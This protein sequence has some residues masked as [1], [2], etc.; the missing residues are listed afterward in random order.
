MTARQSAHGE[1]REKIYPRLT[2]PPS[3]YIALLI[4][5]PCHYGHKVRTESHGAVRTAPCGTRA[6]LTV[7]LLSARTYGKCRFRRRPL[8]LLRHEDHPTAVT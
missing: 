6:V 1:K 5:S 2:F 8:F 4:S 7:S 3:F